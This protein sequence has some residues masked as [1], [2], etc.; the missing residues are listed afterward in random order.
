MVIKT[1]KASQIL[2]VLQALG[3]KVGGGDDGQVLVVVTLYVVVVVTE[4]RRGEGHGGQQQLV[5]PGGAH[6]GLVV[7]VLLQKGPQAG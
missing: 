1:A 7:G 5:G 3:R 4:G 6:Q 2:H